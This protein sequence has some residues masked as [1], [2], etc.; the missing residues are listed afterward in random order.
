MKE[1]IERKLAQEKE[2][3]ATLA[4]ATQ[5]QPATRRKWTISGCVTWMKRRLTTNG[6]GRP[7]RD[8]SSG[9]VVHCTTN[10]APPA[11]KSCSSAVKCDDEADSIRSHRPT[12]SVFGAEVE[13]GLEDMNFMWKK[14]SSVGGVSPDL[15]EDERARSLAASW[16]G[17]LPDH[18]DENID[19]SAR[20]SLTSVGSTLD[21]FKSC[22]GEHTSRTVNNWTQEG[23]APEL[24][25]AQNGVLLHC[26]VVLSDD[27]NEMLFSLCHHCWE[28]VSSTTVP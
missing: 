16:A 19:E 4:A 17:W 13:E 12:R 10:D 20:S 14:L 6:G 18:E 8:V 15:E 27:F 2:L 3:V 5:A 7:E 1:A 22:P 11:L 9:G 26:P 24:D 25:G 28:G 21:V 23:F